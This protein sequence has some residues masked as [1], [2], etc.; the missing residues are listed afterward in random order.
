MLVKQQFKPSITIHSLIVYTH[1]QLEKFGDGWSYCLRSNSPGLPDPAATR[2]L[3]IALR[4]AE[5]IV[6][7]GVL[8]QVAMWNDSMGETKGTNTTAE[9]TTMWLLKNPSRINLREYPSK[10]K[11]Q[12]WPRRKIGGR[13]WSF[14]DGYGSFGFIWYSFI[15]L[16]SAP[17]KG[18]HS[19]WMDV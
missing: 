2:P 11:H 16:S 19:W 9:D 15:H 6:G 4:A 1:N 8:W 5:L 13:C 12:Q 18:K 7:P 3:R 10:K 17:R 14:L